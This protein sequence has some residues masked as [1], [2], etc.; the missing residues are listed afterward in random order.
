MA[1]GAPTLYAQYSN[2]ISIAPL[3][4]LQLQTK[5]Q[6]GRFRRHPGG[7]ADASGGSAMS[8][9]FNPAGGFADPMGG[10]TDP[11]GVVSSIGCPAHGGRVGRAAQGAGGAAQGV[12]RAAQGVRP[13]AHGPAIP[14]RT[15]GR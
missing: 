2:I 1:D 11:I 4:A 5:S 15:S 9:S 10:A 13:A 3:F 8:G 12:G 6:S 7:S 14:L